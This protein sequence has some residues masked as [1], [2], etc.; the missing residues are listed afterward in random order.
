MF[1]GPV[2]AA[3]LAAVEAICRDQL[4]KDYQVSMMEVA[5]PKAKEIN[6]LR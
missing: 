1:V 3:Q 5:L 6:G 2:D 4:A